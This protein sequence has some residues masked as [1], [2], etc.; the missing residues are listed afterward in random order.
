MASADFP[1]YKPYMAA[2]ERKSPTAEQLKL[3]EVLE[4]YVDEINPR[5]ETSVSLFFY[6]VFRKRESERSFCSNLAKLLIN[7]SKLF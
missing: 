7:G 1:V 3:S 4:K 2:L 6:N 5:E